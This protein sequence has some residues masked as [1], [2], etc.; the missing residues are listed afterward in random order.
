M[1]VRGLSQRSVAGGVGVGTDVYGGDSEI[2][3]TF[4]YTPKGRT[5]PGDTGAEI[6]IV[7]PTGWSVPQG[8]NGLAGYT[9]GTDGT[10]E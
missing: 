5:D 7:P 8:S 2:A 1:T 9:T 3:I 4:I 10:D 6:R